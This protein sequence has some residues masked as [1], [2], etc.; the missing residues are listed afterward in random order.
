[1]VRF[2]NRAVPYLIASIYK[3]HG[4]VSGPLGHT[5]SMTCEPVGDME[6][7]SQYTLDL[8]AGYT[9]CYYEADVHDPPSFAK[10]NDV[11]LLAK[12]WD[13]LSPQ[14]MGWSPLV[15][16]DKPIALKYWMVIYK[17]KGTKVWGGIKQTWHSWKV[18]D[19]LLPRTRANLP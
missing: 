2:T 17:R 6:N 13:D 3:A 1:M 18:C 8:A 19:K 15:I 11:D 4:S 10:S 12:I 9:L 5:L 7:G 14:W 16:R